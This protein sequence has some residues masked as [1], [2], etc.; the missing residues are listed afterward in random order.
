[1][2]TMQTSEAPD[3][4]ASSSTVELYWVP[5]CSACMRMKEF[6]EKSGKAFDAINL[7]ASPERGE[8]VRS[9]GLWAPAASVGDRVVNGHNLDQVAELI[10]VLYE[11]RTLLPPE[12]LFERY[13]SISAALLRYLGQMT[14]E[15]QQYNL[16]DRRRTM[17]L[18]GHHTSTIAR[19]YL[20]AYY[21]DKHDKSIY[22]APDA[23]VTLDEVLA[24]T[25]ETRALL[26][27]WWEED[28]Q[29]DPLDRVLETDDGWR[30]L[31]EVFEREV[32]HTTQHTRQLMYA[33]QQHN[34]TPDG[35]LT[36]G[37]LVGL[38]VPERVHA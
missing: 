13:N 24:A 38:P 15:V 33:L 5:G 2:S 9:N 6:V 10:G 35:P 12:A 27:T 30:T 22:G 32:W 34:I 21:N 31:H 29:D 11:A 1:M 18:L 36:A 7:E 8:K 16:P 3:T 23:V 20:S 17:L 25:A 19:A 37:D 28:G 4:D 14:E 26:N